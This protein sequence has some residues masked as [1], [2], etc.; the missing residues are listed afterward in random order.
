MRTALT[1]IDAAIAHLERARAAAAGD[2]RGYQLATLAALSEAAQSLEHGAKPAAV[3]RARAAGASWADVGAALH[4]T[5]Q[6]AQQRYGP[7]A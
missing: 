5:R 2:T 3:E 4:T 7:V 6:A 1:S